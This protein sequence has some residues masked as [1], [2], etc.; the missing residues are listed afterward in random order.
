[1]KR[2]NKFSTVLVLLIVFLVAS[3]AF[4]VDPNSP[5]KAENASVNIYSNLSDEQFDQ[6]ETNLL[7]GMK[8]KNSGL[9]TSCAYRLGELKSDKAM[10]PLLKLVTNGETE[11]ERIIAGLSL[12]KIESN[13]GMYR[14]KWLAENDESELARKVFKRIYAKYVS[15]HYSFEEL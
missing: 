2:S 14:L 9:Q 10:I 8:S 3:K 7:A 15:D 6:F 12:Y 1:M 4:A 5:S 13:I 11:E